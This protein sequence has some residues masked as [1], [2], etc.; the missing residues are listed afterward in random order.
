MMNEVKVDET[1]RPQN[2]RQLK[3]N[4]NREINTEK[5]GL[6]AKSKK[7]KKDTMVH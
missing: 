1:Q 2:K 5:R 4:E 6:K 3:L 7:E